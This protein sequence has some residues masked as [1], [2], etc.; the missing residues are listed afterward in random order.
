M[1]LVSTFVGFV[2]QVSAVM[3]QPTFQSFMIVL[4]GWVFARRRTVTGMILAADAGS[5]HG[6]WHQAIFRV[7]Q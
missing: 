1:N 5:G 3:T 2:Q 7:C 6:F 4:T